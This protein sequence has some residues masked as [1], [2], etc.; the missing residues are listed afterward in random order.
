[1]LATVV[2]KYFKKVIKTDIKRCVTD[3]ATV[4]LS[5]KETSFKAAQKSNFR[6]IKWFLLQI[7]LWLKKVL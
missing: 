1:M 7:K 4:I 5:D 2:K 3:K 6:N